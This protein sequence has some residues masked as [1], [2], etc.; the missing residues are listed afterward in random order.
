[1]L[2]LWAATPLQ[3]GIFS[4]APATTTH[5]VFVSPP[6]RL[7]PPSLQSSALT[8]NLP[9]AA[10][11]VTW[12]GQKLPPFTTR[13][14]ALA[15]FSWRGLR[16]AGVNG[17]LVANTTLY[18]AD[19]DCSAPASVSPIPGAVSGTFEVDDGHGC[20]E[21]IKLDPT[22]GFLTLVCNKYFITWQNQQ[23]YTTNE[24]LQLNAMARF[25]K[26]AYYTQPVQANVSI[27]DGGVLETL[28]LGPQTALPTDSFNATLFEYIIKYGIPPN[29]PGFQK[30]FTSLQ[31]K[32]P[33]PFDVS[34]ET[35]L[36]HHFRQLQLGYPV[37]DSILAD[38][39]MSRQNLTFDGFVT[40]TVAID[41]ASR[42]GQ[43]LLFAL[44]IT[45]VTVNKDVSDA[46]HP[47]I[48]TSSLQSIQL[49]RG[50]TYSVQAVLGFIALLIILLA[51]FYYKRFLPFRSDPNSIAFLAALASRHSFLEHFK[52]LDR[53]VDFVSCL[54]Y[55]QATLRSRD[56][57]LSLSLDPADEEHGRHELS[58]GSG[59]I[60][61][62][63][64]ADKQ[65]N[66][67]NS[68]P[69]E[70]QL[71]AGLGFVLVLCLALAALIFLDTWTRA[72]QGLP[73]PSDKTITRQI[74]LSY[75]PTVRVPFPQSLRALYR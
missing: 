37:L 42:A 34:Q 58:E 64:R 1:M 74:I 13:E 66:L 2:V 9:N 10:Y 31:Q 48:Y 43:Q 62:R 20:K 67:H 4:I 24:I 18:R 55:Q 6:A 26:T 7:L 33:R 60:E 27:S 17:S 38:I 53:E 14:F 47:A 39:A 21:T 57:S 3:S 44:A 36:D 23:A 71:P 45:M 63:A 70:L 56:G 46:T 75:L 8:G 25:C 5:D 30:N 54:R 28:P 59:L 61:A 68:W 41:A 65:P 72:H 51:G 50:I 12:L 49:V 35:P 73:L 16:T 15:P 22:N 32:V 29:P 19:L 52:P 40:D 69:R 11:G